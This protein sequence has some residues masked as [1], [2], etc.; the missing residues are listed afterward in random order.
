MFNWNYLRI[1]GRKKKLS[2]GLSKNIEEGKKKKEI[3]EIPQEEVEQNEPDKDVVSDS[4]L[5]DDKTYPVVYND[6]ESCASSDNEASFTIDNFQ[7]KQNEDLVT[8][9]NLNA[10]ISTLPDVV[11]FKG[12]IVLN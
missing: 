10:E 1:A 4:S 3:V 9:E 8:Y 6:N 12:K 7:S 2:P 5:I 11:D